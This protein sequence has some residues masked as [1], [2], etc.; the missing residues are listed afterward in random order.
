MREPPRPGRLPGDPGRCTGE[1][2]RVAVEEGPR[3]AEGAGRPARPAHVP[4]GPDRHPV[5]GR[6]PGSLR[7]PSVGRPVD[8]TARARPR[9]PDAAGPLH[10][11][12]QACRRSGPAPRR[13]TGVPGRR[14]PCDR[15]CAA[16]RKRRL[17]LPVRRRGAVPGDVLEGEPYAPWATGL[18]EEAQA[19]YLELLTQLAAAAA[20]SDDHHSEAYY[21]L[22]LLERDPYDED[23]HLGLVSLLTATGRHGEARRRYLVYATAMNEIEVPPAAFPSALRGTVAGRGSGVMHGSSGRTRARANGAAPR[24]LRVGGGPLSH[25]PTPSAKSSAG[26]ARTACTAQARVHSPHRHPPSLTWTNVSET[27]ATLLT[28][29]QDTATVTGGTRDWARGRP[30][31]RRCGHGG[32]SR[33]PRSGVGQARAASG[34]C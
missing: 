21:R 30:A 20:E 4:R 8:G 33:C 15:R 27:D 19:V 11:R 28:T 29:S 12:R 16:H 23:A 13:R 6:G 34:L 26:V 7:Q 2:R 17:R 32:L 1:C 24:R 14:P 9:T 22:R 25:S 10:H 5:A 18:R 31:T 3:S